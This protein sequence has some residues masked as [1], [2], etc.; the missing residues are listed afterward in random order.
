MQT[1]HRNWKHLLLQLRGAR[2]TR[3]V[4]L[5]P[6]GR[7]VKL[8]NQGLEDFSR[9]HS[10]CSPANPAVHSFF[11][12]NHRSYLTEFAP[13]SPLF[14]AAEFLLQL[15]PGLPAPSGRHR[16]TRSELLTLVTNATRSGHGSHRHPHGIGVLPSHRIQP[17]P[18]HAA[19]L[20]A[21]VTSRLPEQATAPHFP[22]PRIRPQGQSSARGRGD[23]AKGQ[24]EAVF[25]STSRHRHVLERAGGLGWDALTCCAREA[26]ASR[27]MEPPTQTQIFS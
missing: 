20:G 15:K 12:L 8:Q 2:G 3:N 25:R 13:C 19:R 21:P 22:Q 23:A 5:L 17:R 18:S 16:C 4:F 1:P 6:H 7:F 9:V 27:N 10:L 24:H 26:A 11:V 14:K